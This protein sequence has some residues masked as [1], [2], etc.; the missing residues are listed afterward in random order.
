MAA[1]IVEVR[2]GDTAIAR[3]TRRHAPPRPRCYNVGHGA[4]G[5]PTTHNDMQQGR[6]Y[7]VLKDLHSNHQDRSI[8]LGQMTIPRSRLG[9]RLPTL[10]SLGADRTIAALADN[11]T[12]ARTLA[13]ARLGCRAS[14]A[15]QGPAS[16]EGAVGRHD[17]DQ[18]NRNNSVGRW[19]RGSARSARSARTCCR[20]SPSQCS[21]SPCC[22]CNNG[23][24]DF[25]PRNKGVSAVLVRCS[26][27]YP[28]G[29]IADPLLLH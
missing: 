5:L 29:L 8:C 12:R 28:R 23:G 24:P 21:A 27:A 22:A 1:A 14:N 7:S 13:A 9:L 18:H 26:S 20:A 10:Q 4:A 2:P 25:G 3:N 17:T 6:I 15:T 19:P 11:A 16:C